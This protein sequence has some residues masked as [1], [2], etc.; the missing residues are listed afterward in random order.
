MD[1]ARFGANEAFPRKLP[2]WEQMLDLGRERI[3]RE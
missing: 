1:L 3:T 2:S